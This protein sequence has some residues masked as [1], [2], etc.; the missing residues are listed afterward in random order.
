M[1]S[2]ADAAGVGRRTLVEG[3]HLQAVDVEVLPG[4]E[5]LVVERG[6]LVRGAAVQLG[7]QPQ[8]EVAAA[9]E[10]ISVESLDR[11]PFWH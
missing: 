9:E 11:C 4:G 2:D 7:V 6:A 1:G 8:T 3:P 10:R 5:R